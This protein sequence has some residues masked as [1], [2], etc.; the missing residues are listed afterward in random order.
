MGVV[1]K[2]K[3]T[4]AATT[5]TDLMWEETKIPARVTTRLY[6][7]K[8]MWTKKVIIQDEPPLFHMR[9]YVRLMAFSTPTQEYTKHALVPKGPQDQQQ[10]A[11]VQE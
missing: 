8:M 10:S 4:T 5:I 6:P 3:P 9:N 2:T 7:T 11:V 1:P